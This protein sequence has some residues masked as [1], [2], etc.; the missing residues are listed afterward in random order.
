MSGARALIV[1]LVVI[2]LAAAGSMAAGLSSVGLEVARV[3]PAVGPSF[4][5]HAR[6]TCDTTAGGVEIKPTGSYNL[7]S[8]ECTAKG[9][10]VVGG[11]NTLSAATGTEYADGDRFGANVQQPE[12]CITASGSVVVQCRFLVSSQ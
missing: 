11:G 3:A 2:G 12:R 1:G 8:Y 5:R 10:V 7:I 6:I 9:D 4:P